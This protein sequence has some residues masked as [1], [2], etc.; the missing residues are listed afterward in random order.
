[1]I[2]KNTYKKMKKLVKEYENSL[3]EK[4]QD[5]S[6]FTKEQEKPYIIT[7][8]VKES[9]KYNPKYGDNRECECGHSYY[10]HFD[11]YEDMCAVGCK[12][13]ECYLFK[14]KK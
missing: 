1:M 5:V 12:Y 7:E 2:S 3:K 4:K 11:S 8:T 6:S 13:C 14:E 10:R 9:H